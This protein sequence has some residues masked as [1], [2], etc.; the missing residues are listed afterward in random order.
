MNLPN[1]ETDDNLVYGLD[2]AKKDSQLAVLS[3]EGRQLANFRF[4]STRENFLEVARSL[5]PADT[6]R[7]RGLNECQCGDVDL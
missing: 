1:F 7:T 6:C 4:P 3:S 2:L 5:R